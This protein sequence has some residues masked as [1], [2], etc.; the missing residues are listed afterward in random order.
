MRTPLVLVAGLAAEAAHDVAHAF[1]D[2][3]TA[4]VHHDLGRLDQSVLNRRIRYASQDN[5]TTVELTHG[6]VSC[7]LREEL[8]P[9]LRRVA[10]RAGVERIVLHLDPALE[11]ETVCW[12][13]QRMP[14]DGHLVD[15][16][17]D[18]AAVLTVLDA[19]SWLAHATGS[20]SVQGCGYA[21]EHTTIAP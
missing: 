3:R 4:V 13:M 21:R 19:A 9:L 20:A 8:L 10:A 15:E 1:D 18:V 2:P 5:A 14:V 7:V 17:I 6:C 12:A 16:G 11:P